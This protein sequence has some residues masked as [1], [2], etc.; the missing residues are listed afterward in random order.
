MGTDTQT[1]DGKDRCLYITKLGY[2]IQCDEY[3]AVETVDSIAVVDIGRGVFGNFLA[4]SASMHH[5]RHHQC[6]L[7]W[8]CAEDRMDN[9]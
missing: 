6:Y 9:A 2:C 4:R 3:L 7:I 5:F 8:H 1:P